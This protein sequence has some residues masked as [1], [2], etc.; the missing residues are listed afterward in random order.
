MEKSGTILPTLINS[1]GMEVGTPDGTT[2]FRATMLDTNII[3]MV[4][5][6]NKKNEETQNLL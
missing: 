1:V 4:S 6:M 5:R 2:F 3:E